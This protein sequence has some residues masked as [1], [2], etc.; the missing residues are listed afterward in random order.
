M[1]HPQ[2]A[3]VVV[4]GGGIRGCT[5]AL[6]LAREGL[7]VTL[8]ERRFLSFMTSSANGGQVNV[9]DKNPDYY[10]ALSL[11]SAHMYP[12]FVASLDGEV[13][14][15]QKGILHVATNEEEMANIHQRVQALHQISG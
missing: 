5:I 13:F 6:F 2:T 9:T 12:E 14:L 10:T 3:D 15:Q 1:S 4:I 11:A 7:R 8:V